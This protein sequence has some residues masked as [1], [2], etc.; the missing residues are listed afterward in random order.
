MF[1]CLELGTQWLSL[2]NTDTH[3]F[4]NLALI[5][6]VIVIYLRSINPSLGYNPVDIDIVTYMLSD[7]IT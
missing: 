7:I 3:L 2:N 5:V 6:I 1:A 4:R